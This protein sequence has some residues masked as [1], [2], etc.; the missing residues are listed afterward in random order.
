MNDDT[1]KEVSVDP[2]EGIQDNFKI[3]TKPVEVKEP[4]VVQVPPVEEAPVVV[5]QPVESTPVVEEDKVEEQVEVVESEANVVSET[6][7]AADINTE[8][9]E[10][11]QPVVMGTIDEVSVTV[12]SESFNTLKEDEISEK[13]VFKNP[14][15]TSDATS[16]KEG[17]DKQPEKKGFPFFML[18]IFILVVGAAFFIDDISLWVK[19]YQ[20][21]KNKKTET[22]EKVDTKEEEE[23]EEDQAKVLTLTEIDDAVKNSSLLFTFEAEKNIEITPILE[24]NKITYT[25]TN[26][27][28][29]TGSAF[30]VEYVFENN[31]LTSEVDVANSDFGYQMSIIIVKEI[32]K[33]QGLTSTEIDNYVLEKAETNTLDNGF[34]FIKNEDGSSTYKIATN[35]KVDINK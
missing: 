33:L 27:I 9:E 31:V 19:E 20:A 4:E 30:K 25:T 28:D 10:E 35:V 14:T 7:I 26:Y 12:D 32:A 8:V 29:L 16:M 3:E 1:N 24:A 18:L 2:T 6:V 22:E 34:E 13:S 15:V 21:S 17:M 5:E 23:K 11:T